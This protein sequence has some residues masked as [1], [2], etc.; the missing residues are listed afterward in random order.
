MWLKV[1]KIVISF[2]EASYHDLLT[3]IR[4]GLL[5]HRRKRR[6]KFIFF[7]C[8]HTKE[9]FDLKE[10]SPRRNVSLGNE[11]HGCFQLR[12]KQGPRPHGQEWFKQQ[13]L[14]LLVIPPILEANYARKNVVVLNR[15]ITN[16]KEL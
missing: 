16:P 15:L 7:F 10:M 2:K 4:R 8:N 1:K 5:K 12:D 13:F 3:L 6:Q 9:H 11:A 14:H